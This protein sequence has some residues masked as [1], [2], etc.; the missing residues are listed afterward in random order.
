MAIGK[1]A[2]HNSDHEDESDEESDEGSSGDES[3]DYGFVGGTLCIIR[4]IKSND[5]TCRGAASVTRT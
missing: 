5:T 2:R 3:Y 4:Q 1:A